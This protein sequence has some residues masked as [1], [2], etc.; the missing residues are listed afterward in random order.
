MFL[1][2][3][4][5]AQRFPEDKIE[6]EKE[7]LNHIIKN[8][9]INLEMNDII[10]ELENTLLMEFNDPNDRKKN[11]Y[12]LPLYL[13]LDKFPK[14][15]NAI[16]TKINEFSDN[17]IKLGASIIPVERNRVTYV[18]FD[19]YTELYIQEKLFEFRQLLKSLGNVAVKNGAFIDIPYGPLKELI[20]PRIGRYGSLIHNVKKFFDP[21]N[22]LNPGKIEWEVTSYE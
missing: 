13:T 4:E 9:S 17:N 6:Y 3:L 14:L 21:N 5:G 18:E 12:E 1:I 8:Q 15:Y 2:C 7:A 22:I 10:Y 19:F 20:Y 11:F 16:Q